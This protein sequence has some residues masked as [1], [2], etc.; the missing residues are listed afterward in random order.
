MKGREDIPAEPYGNF[1]DGT[2]SVKHPIPQEISG[3]AIYY[4]PYGKG[5][6]GW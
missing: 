4:D 2:T 6:R 1:A 5:I 3:T